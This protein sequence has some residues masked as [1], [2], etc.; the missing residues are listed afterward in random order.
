MLIEQLKE[1]KNNNK[2]S[3]P[4]EPKLNRVLL[5]TLSFF[6]ICFGC[7]NFLIIDD[8]NIFTII[9]IVFG[10]VFYT[11][12]EYFK[13]NKIIEYSKNR[14]SSSLVVAIIT[15]LISLTSIYGIFQTLEKYTVVKPKE[16]SYK[17]QIDSLNKV[18]DSNYADS[19]IILQNRELYSRK[20]SDSVKRVISM[21][22]DEILKR[23][24]SDISSLKAK[25]KSENITLNKEYD[26]KSS[27][28]FIVIL[29]LIFM[30]LIVEISIVNLCYSHGINLTSYNKLLSDYNR[31]QSKIFETPEGKRF[32][33]FLTG[34][35]YIYSASDIGGKFY[36][37]KFKHLGN[38]SDD[39]SNLLVQLNIV[40]NTNILMNKQEAIKA[41][42]N[43]F[44]SILNNDII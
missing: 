10:V 35:N 13:D 37:T 20:Q 12:N 36:K 34:L 3:K 27:S 24:K 1:I 26:T 21:K 8:I 41:L 31:E 2:I 15:I 6:S 43:Y 25:E 42:D 44:Y 9:T 23:I 30:V 28:K 33:S 29:F 7:F 11:M 38:Q 19:V 32:I 22:K 4:T 17:V 39:F 14:S 16:V 40:D 18:S 5:T